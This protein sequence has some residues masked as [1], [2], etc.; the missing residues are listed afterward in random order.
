MMVIVQISSQL[1]REL[2]RT[3]VWMPWVER[4][5]RVAVILA[6][7]WLVTRV[8]RRL[9]GRLRV[10]AARMIEKHGGVSDTDL[11]KRA[12]TIITV[13]VKLASV[14]IWLVALV[15]SLS[16]LTFNVQPLLAGLGVA[17]LALGLGAQTLIKDWLGGLFILIEDQVRIG[18]A[19]TVSGVSGSVE[20]VNL[21]TTVLR[22][23]NGAVHII[24]NGSITQITNFTREYSY[25]L[26]ETTLA[27][28]ADLNRAL[29]VVT[30]AGESLVDDERFKPML[31]SGLEVMGVERF[32]D[33]GMLIRARIKTMPS[34]Q[35]MVGRELNLRVKSGLDAA[36]IPFPGV[37][38]V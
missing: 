21:R 16:E 9:I 14:A 11:E 33:R 4:L 30:Q 2:Q 18:D 10:R 35:A 5:I 37:A 1:L 32:T 38:S 27:Y 13:L 17:G 34:K 25:Y 12:A 36:G 23:E 15:M 3:E 19:V 24:P 8:A 26:F 6:V 31:L 28:G 29:E 20:E 7:A 22:A